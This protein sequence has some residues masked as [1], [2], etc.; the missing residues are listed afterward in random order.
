MT[1]GSAS[2][3]V[4]L[5][6]AAL[7]AQSISAGSMVRIFLHPLTQ[8]NIGSS[9]AATCAPHSGR[10][11][12]VIIC[13]TEAVTGDWLQRNT[14]KVMLPVGMDPITDSIKH[15]LTFSSIPTPT[16]GL[17]PTSLHA[18]LQSFDGQKP[19][20]VQASG[21]LVYVPPSATASLVIQEGD[22]NTRPFRSD[23][24][25][26]LYVKIVLGAIVFANT[27]GDAV[28]RV[29]LPAGYA[30]TGAGAVA[31]KLGILA[32][33]VPDGFGSL[34]TG[35]EGSWSSV[36]STTGT[37]SRC[38][39]TLGAGM[40]VFAGSSFFVQM[41]VTN[42]PFPLMQGLPDAIW[43][44]EIV[45]KGFHTNSLTSPLSSFSGSGDLASSV[46]VLGK[47]SEEIIMPSNFA[48]GASDNWLSV[49]FRT[50]RGIQQAQGYVYV[51]SPAFFDFGAVCEARSLP[52]EYYTKFN[53]G[54][55]NLSN[56]QLFTLRL[57]LASSDICIGSPR[58]STDIAHNRAKILLGDVLFG[59]S[60]YGFQ[61]KVINAN[62]YDPQQ[63]TDWRIWIYTNMMVRIEGSTGPPRINPYDLISAGGWGVHDVSLHS[64]NLAIIIAD[65]RPNQQATQ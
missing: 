15:T 46:S 57:P 1:S 23:I 58:A 21:A 45:A 61:L 19:Q 17:L 12:G 49:F 62:F 18:E 33:T 35:V 31:A 41:S 37:S 29:V 2:F 63:P 30:C 60:M 38:E 32:G 56:S 54:T 5:R 9:C 20:Y 39:Y 40:A 53:P 50:D 14:L 11:C 7:A 43:A 13:S 25:N 22:G 48:R 16:G 24:G 28:L 55:T 3:Q 36:P 4:E 47:L 27:G 42:P 51:D 34:N 44:C 65:M 52:A 6:A 10:T 8:W 59:L 64:S 26:V